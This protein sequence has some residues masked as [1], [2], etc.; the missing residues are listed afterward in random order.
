[1][2][3][4]C[5]E[6]TDRPRLIARVFYPFVLKGEVLME[7]LIRLSVALA[8]FIVMALSELF[9]P[10]RMTVT[11][12]KRWPINLSIAAFNMLIMRITIGAAAYSAAMW[13][14]ENQWGLLNQLVLPE[15]L[16]VVLTLLVLDLAIYCQHIISHKWSLLWRLHQIHHCDLEF[17]LTTAVRFH[18]LEIFLSMLYKIIWVIA[19]GADPWAVIV[20]E[21]VLNACAT[22]NH[23]NISL[24]ARLES[25]LRYIL[26]TPDIHRIHH[27]TL[28]D[29]TDSN[30]GFSIS[31]WDRLFKTFRNQPQQDQGIMLIGLPEYRDETRLSF[32]RLMIL[33][34]RSK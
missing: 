11:R 13:A 24:P 31:L 5:L 15:W 17:D 14:M 19:L 30:Y 4:H 8:V 27:S 25:C 34:F 12:K 23:S 22:F 2:V 29:E 32:W 7:W 9:F 21:M 10:K 33:P 6:V 3:S 28:R 20:F 18:P 16:N 26:I 1:M